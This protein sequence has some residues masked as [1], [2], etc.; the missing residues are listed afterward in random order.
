VGGGG[1]AAV[2]KNQKG[3][4]IALTATAKGVRFTLPKGG[5]DVRLKK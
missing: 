1:C 5:M 4:E 3:V 2:L